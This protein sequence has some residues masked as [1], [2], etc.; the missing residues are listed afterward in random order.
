MTTGVEDLL[1]AILHDRPRLLGV[2]CKGRPD[3]WDET[4]CPEIVEYAI[5]VCHSCPVR[6]ECEQWVAGLPV[7]KWLR[8]VVAGYASAAEVTANRSNLNDLGGAA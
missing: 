5:N 2:K 3:V 7:S 1:V 6:Q 8:G 4:D